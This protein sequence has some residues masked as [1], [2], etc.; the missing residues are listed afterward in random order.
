[1]PAPKAKAKAPSSRQ[2]T[3]QVVPQASRG[4]PRLY[5]P[6]FAGIAYGMAKF[7]A[8]DFDICQRLGI[9]VETLHQWSADYPDFSEALKVGKKPADERVK[10][11]L[12]H[13]AVGYD[14]VEEEIRIVGDRVVRMPV[15]R[16]MPPSETAMKMWLKIGRAA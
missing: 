16:H 13:R 2:V 8:T 11:S 15:V 9:S 3:M 12:Y 10:R 6:K 14:Y 4:R 7:G 5:S 1:M